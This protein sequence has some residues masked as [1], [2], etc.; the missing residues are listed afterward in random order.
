[1]LTILYDEY[2]QN[3]QMM[4]EQKVIANRSTE[5]V[6][7]NQQNFSNGHGTSFK[8]MLWGVATDHD[9]CPYH[10]DTSTLLVRLLDIF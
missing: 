1:M 4:N 3:E 9:D 7:I 6:N 10:N 8:H 2:P 5:K